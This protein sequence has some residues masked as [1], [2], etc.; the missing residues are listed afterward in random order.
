MNVE[1][2]IKILVEQITRLGVK[3]AD[4]K[5]SARGTRRRSW[6]G[7]ALNIRASKRP[8]LQRLVCMVFLAFQK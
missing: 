5:L 6:P 7:A 8:V 2:E 3:N 4:G 1:H